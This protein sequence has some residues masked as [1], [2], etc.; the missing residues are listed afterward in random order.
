MNEQRNEGRRLLHPI[1]EVVQ[2]LG[3][4]RTTVYEL[5]KTGDLHPIHIGRCCRISDEELVRFVRERDR[6]PRKT[7][8]KGRRPA[9][10][11]TDLFEVPGGHP[12]ETIVAL[13]QTDSARTIK[14]RR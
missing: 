7:A 6:A 13:P 5:I 2:I 1:E 8:T 3:I 4:G 10:V 12:Q 11:Q 14:A 9:P